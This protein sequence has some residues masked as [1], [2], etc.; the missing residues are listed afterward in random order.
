MKA[1]LQTSRLHQ[2]GVSN[3]TCRYF[4]FICFLL[5]VA[6]LRLQLKLSHQLVCTLEFLNVNIL[7]TASTQSMA[8]TAIPLF[9]YAGYYEATKWDRRQVRFL[10]SDIEPVLLGLIG[11]APAIWLLT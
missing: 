7:L 3:G 6:Q 10:L 8:T 9:Y 1:K 2:A 4:T 5:F 11:G